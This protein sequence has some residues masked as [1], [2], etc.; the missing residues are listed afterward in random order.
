VDTARIL[1]I[2]GFHA[3][4]GGRGYTSLLS[5]R[6][7]RIDLSP[8][9]RVDRAVLVGWGPAGTAWNTGWK[10]SGCEV[11]SGESLGES[12][13]HSLWRMVV[14]IGPATTEPLP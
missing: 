6:L 14:A 2:A 5:G 7:E 3:A 10:E 12:E 11:P 1:E 8:L 13:G 9:L 4:V